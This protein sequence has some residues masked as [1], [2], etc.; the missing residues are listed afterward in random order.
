[1][2]ASKGDENDVAAAHR[3]MWNQHSRKRKA[4]Q[5]RIIAAKDCEEMAKEMEEVRTVQLEDIAK[6]LLSMSS[7]H[8][9]TCFPIGCSPNLPFNSRP[10]QIDSHTTPQSGISSLTAQTISKL[11]DF[12]PTIYSQENTF[13][14]SLPLPTTMSRSVNFKS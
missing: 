1:M 6:I 14:S 11:V 9:L 13:C 2:K 7:A 5:Y 12:Y 10:T 4:M 3:I 8:N